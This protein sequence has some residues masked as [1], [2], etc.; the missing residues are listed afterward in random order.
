MSSITKKIS[1]EIALHGSW[2]AYL[3]WQA[4]Q[5]QGEVQ[6][7]VEAPAF[8]SLPGPLSRSTNDRGFAFYEFKDMYGTECK[9]LKSSAALTDAIWLGVKDAEPMI[10]VS[11]A[12]KLG[13]PSELYSHRKGGWM[14]Y[15]IPQEVSLNTQMHLSRPMAQRLIEVLQ[16][17]V[18]TGEI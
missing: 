9:L 11:D 13:L 12:I 10:M 8:S 7:K 6:P 18:D 1:D 5:N 16:Q 2:E 17:F 3:E 14:K 4:S 15:P